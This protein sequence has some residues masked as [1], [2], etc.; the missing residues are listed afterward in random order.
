MSEIV[1]SFLIE[2]QTTTEE[3]RLYGWK[4]TMPLPRSNLS[5]SEVSVSYSTSALECLDSLT[6]R[7]SC[8]NY[9]SVEYRKYL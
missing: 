9:D 2:A 6:K 8:L 7:V 3:G 5:Y 1:K 4:L